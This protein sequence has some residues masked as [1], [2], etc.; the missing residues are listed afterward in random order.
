M[1]VVKRYGG[2]LHCKAFFLACSPMDLK[3]RVERAHCSWGDGCEVDE[4]QAE[5]LSADGE[6]KAGS[7]LPGI[8]S[9]ILLTGELL[10]LLCRMLMVRRPVGSFGMSICNHHFITAKWTWGQLFSFAGKS[11]VFSF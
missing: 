9:L 7:S 8:G 11:A 1:G 3:V 5:L 6:Q 4:L 2:E 10:V